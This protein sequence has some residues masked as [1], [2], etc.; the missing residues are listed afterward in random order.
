LDEFSQNPNIWS[1]LRK[2]FNQFDTTKGEKLVGKPFKTAW[3]KSHGAAKDIESPHYHSGLPNAK[4]K[5]VQLDEIIYNKHGQPIG[6]RTYDQTLKLGGSNVRYDSKAWAPNQIKARLKKSP[7]VKVDED[8]LEEFG[9]AYRDIVDMAV[10]GDWDI[11]WGFDAR[12]PDWISPD[13]KSPQAKVP[14][15][16]KKVIDENPRI[17]DRLMTDDGTWNILME[18]LRDNL[19]IF[20]DAI[21]WDVVD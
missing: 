11:Q 13:G 19:A 14:E 16:I 10:K 6:K 21:F 15:W 18:T 4:I 5:G 9:Q 2:V 1:G 7:S 20:G 8:A 12:S 17:Q 3:S